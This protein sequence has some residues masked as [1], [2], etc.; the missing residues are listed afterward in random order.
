MILNN[1]AVKNEFT[2]NP[3]T[4]LSH[5]NI[6]NALIINKNSP[7]VIKVIGKVNNTRIGF[8]KI[9]NNPRT[10]AT[11]IAVV[12]LSTLTPFIKCEMISTKIDVIRI[13]KS[14]FMFLILNKSSNF[15]LNHFLSKKEINFGQQKKHL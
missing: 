1:N 13:L 10:T 2:L 5:N 11:I 3:P 4:M 8:I 9:F 6:I 12:K 7:K 15:K 14:N